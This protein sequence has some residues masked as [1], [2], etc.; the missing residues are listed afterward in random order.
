MLWSR[1]GARVPSTMWTVS[2]RGRRA[3]GRRDGQQRCEAIENVVGRGLRD[4]EQRRRD[5]KAQQDQP[6]A[7][8]TAAAQQVNTGHES[9]VRRVEEFQDVVFAVDGQ[10]SVGVPDQDGAIRSIQRGRHLVS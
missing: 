4:P 10:A 9:R 6:T 3:A 1:V 8:D 2:W 7:A 5:L